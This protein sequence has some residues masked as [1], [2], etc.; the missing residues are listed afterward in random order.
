MKTIED[1]KIQMECILILGANLLWH[2]Y[3]NIPMVQLVHFP[4]TCATVFTI[5]VW[6]TK[7]TCS[8]NSGHFLCKYFE[9]ILL[10][11]NIGILFS[12]Y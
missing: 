2:K 12:S 8:K 6:V 7:A 9:L 1:R 11:I 10:L 3:N 5:S 4:Q